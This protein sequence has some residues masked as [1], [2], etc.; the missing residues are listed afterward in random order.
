MSQQRVMERHTGQ[1]GSA[2]AVARVVLVH[3]L[4]PSKGW[5]G[6]RRSMVYPTA[7][8]RLGSAGGVRRGKEGE[9]GKKE[10]K[11]DLLPLAHPWTP[12]PQHR[13]TARFSL[14]RRAVTAP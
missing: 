13:S 14:P 1:L 5:L 6:P 10:K 12:I 7:S 8:R 9:G 4:F 2:R 3:V 11:G